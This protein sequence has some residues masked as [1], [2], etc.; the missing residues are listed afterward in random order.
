MPAP[1]CYSGQD[2]LAVN[3][4]NA[5]AADFFRLSAREGD[6]HLPFDVDAR[7]CFT[8]WDVSASE[9]FGTYVYE[10]TAFRRDGTAA[11]GG[12]ELPGP[13]VR[14]AARYSG[15]PTDSNT[16]AKGIAI[17]AGLTVAGGGLLALL[18]RR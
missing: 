15:P 12:I 5:A 3:Y 18:S 6:T 13:M 14:P 4:E 2:L 10:W 7:Y 17:A 16:K 9:A 8:R 11:A 1:Y